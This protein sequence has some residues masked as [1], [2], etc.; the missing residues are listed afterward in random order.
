MK[1]YMEDLKILRQSIAYTRIVELLVMA[2]KHG[3][4]Y[5][6]AENQEDYENQILKEADNIIYNLENTLYEEDMHPIVR[7]SLKKT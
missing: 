1:I 7:H 5:F 4:I 6:R 2:E 3:L